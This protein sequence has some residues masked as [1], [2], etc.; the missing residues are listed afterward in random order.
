MEACILMTLNLW[1]VT[2]GSWKVFTHGMT[3][4][5]GGLYSALIVYIKSTCNFYTKR[6]LTCKSVTY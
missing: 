5:V 3:G 4:G 2:S 1:P 6:D